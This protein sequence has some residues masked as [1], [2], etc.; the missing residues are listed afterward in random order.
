MKESVQ[1]IIQAVKNLEDTFDDYDHTN[2]DSVGMLNIAVNSTEM[3]V[4]IGRDSEYNTEYIEIYDSL[5]L[6]MEVLRAKVDA[7]RATFE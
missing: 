5:K 6:K 7:I 4:N 1:K 3:A 2:V